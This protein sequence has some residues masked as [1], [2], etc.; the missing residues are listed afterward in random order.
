[1]GK[2]IDIYICFKKTAK[3]RQ[4]NGG[5]EGDIGSERMDWLNPTFPVL[6]FKHADA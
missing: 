6:L 5:E 3:S 1:M 2:I 4:E